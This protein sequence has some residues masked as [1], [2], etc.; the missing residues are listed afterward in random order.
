MHL[1]NLFLKHYYII[2]YSHLQKIYQP[3]NMTGICVTELS[4][5]KFISI[6]RRL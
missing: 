6:H 3:K 5:E 4:K 1:T 2:Y